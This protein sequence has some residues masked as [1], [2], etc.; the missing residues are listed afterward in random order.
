M[1][2]DPENT[3]ADVMLSVVVPA[4]NEAENVEPLVEQIDAAMVEAGVCYE[5]IIVDD[6]SR[7]QTLEK[8][9]TLMVRYPALRTLHR[10]K[11]RGQ[12]AAMGRGIAMARGSYVATLDADLQNDPADL[13]RMLRMLEEQQADMVQGDRSHARQD[14]MIRRY[15][16]IVGRLFRR[17][18]LGD[19]V[20][21]TGCSARV[22]RASYAK[23]IPLQYN[24]IHRFFPA[25][26]A[27]MGG[28]VV[29]MAAS[30]RPRVAGETKYGMGIL[31]RGPRA[32][33]DLLAV[34]WMRSRWRDTA[35]EEIHLPDKN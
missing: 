8:L 34:R 7:D 23:Q 11:P 5:L 21:D 24:G 28:K 15:G 18:V 13:P 19:H 26:V 30:H 4:L 32:L 20:R 31:T 9:K 1:S 17:F 10:P 35:V 22:I 6:G 16:S 3:A 2:Q 14:H 33:F 29:E 12:S 27:L 25:Y